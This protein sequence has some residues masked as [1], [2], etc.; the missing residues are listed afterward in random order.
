MNTFLI[1]DGLSIAYRAFHVM[2]K[3]LT[4][5]DGTPTSMITGF[6]NMLLRAQDDL[7]PDC[8]VIVFDTSGKNASGIHVF[9][10]DLQENYKAG[11]KPM[12][13]EMKGQLPILQE[14]LQ[15]LGYRVIV[16]EGVE[17]D[18]VAASIARLAQKN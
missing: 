2:T 18:D 14:L 17:A 7:S 4:A 3:K 1:V 13:D 6:M 8:T 5:P 9:R 11:R 15:Y 10:Y 16:G 12:E